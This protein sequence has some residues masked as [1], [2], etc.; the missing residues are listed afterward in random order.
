MDESVATLER[1][2]HIS[3]LESATKIIPQDHWNAE[4]RHGDVP[5]VDYSY[6]HPRLAAVYGERIVDGRIEACSLEDMV[7]IDNE[8]ATRVLVDE[9]SRPAVLSIAPYPRHSATGTGKE[10]IANNN[11][12]LITIRDG[13]WPIPGTY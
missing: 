5:E 6:P 10:T 8:V 9:H 4:P 7:A 11:A 2:Q 13:H 12:W 1:S 3:G